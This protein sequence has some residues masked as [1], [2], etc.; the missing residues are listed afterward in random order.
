MAFHLAIGYYITCKYSFFLIKNNSLV[1]HNNYKHVNAKFYLN[2]EQDKYCSVTLNELIKHL[3]IYLSISK[4]F[5]NIFFHMFMKHM[6]YPAAVVWVLYAS[7]SCLS[8]VVSLSPDLSSAVPSPPRTCNIQ[9]WSL[10]LRAPSRLKEHDLQHAS[11]LQFGLDVFCSPL[12][13]TTVWEVMNG[14]LL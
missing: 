2:F 3:S 11:R 7:L 14:L 8:S 5:Y 4:T 10:S 13:H 6:S 9:P 12:L 1:R